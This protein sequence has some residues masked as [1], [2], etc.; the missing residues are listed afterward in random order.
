MEFPLGTCTNFRRTQAPPHETRSSFWMTPV[1]IDPSNG[2]NRLACMTLPLVNYLGDPGGGGF[3]ARNGAAL[4]PNR[5]QPPPSHLFAVAHGCLTWTAAISVLLDRGAHGLRCWCLPLG[6]TQAACGCPLVLHQIL[7]HVVPPQSFDC[8]WLVCSM[9]KA[10]IHDSL[11]VFSLVSWALLL[12]PQLLGPLHHFALQ[13]GD[14][15]FGDPTR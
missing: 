6:H 15:G 1:V 7:A 11:A 9:I 8:C 12:P 13:A 10:V 4:P 14:T 3:V 5:E 2:A